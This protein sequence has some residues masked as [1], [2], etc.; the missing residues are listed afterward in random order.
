MQ[1]PSRA[2]PTSRLLAHRADWLLLATVSLLALACFVAGLLAFVIRQRAPR[3]ALLLAPACGVLLVAA[4]FQ[5]AVLWRAW[6]AGRLL[7]VVGRVGTARFWLRLFSVASILYLAALVIGPRPHLGWVWA[8]A[9]AV[10]YSVLLLPLA[11][12]P[13]IL[14]DW[15]QWSQNRFRRRLSWLVPATLSLALLAELG[16][17]TS[18]YLEEQGW[19]ARTAADS[20]VAAAI[21][22]HDAITDFQ[23]IMAGE[24]VRSGPFRVAVATERHAVDGSQDQYLARIRQ[25]LPGLETVPLELPTTWSRRGSAE[26]AAR[27]HAV[28][29][30]LLLVVASACEAVSRDAQPRDWFNWRQLE[31]ARWLGV[32]HD[33]A[34]EVAR[35]SLSDDDFEGFLDGL[36]PQLIACRAPLS[37]Q[38]LARWTQVQAA[39]DELTIRCDA[40]GVPIALVLTPSQFQ[41]NARLVDTLAR[42]AGCERQE[43]DLELPQRKWSAFAESRSVPLVDLLPALRL[44]AEGAYRRNVSTWNDAGDTAAA[45]TIGGW[46]ESRYGGQLAIAAQLTS[47]P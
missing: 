30:D 19:L 13:R 21:A 40:V 9:V 10:G 14:D 41:V 7:E 17:R 15:R 32:S 28:N 11:A 8:A 42:R 6:R 5:A 47:A 31:L 39:L 43:L 26:L 12:S 22:P 23:Y 18:R 44:C 3:G 20:R 35:D 33:P 38:M 37:E 45:T 27:A 2:K 29:A 46:L 4:V 1:L 36:A 16:L 25:M 34:T 24:S